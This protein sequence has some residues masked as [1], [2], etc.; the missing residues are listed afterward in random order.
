MQER[1]QLRPEIVAELQQIV[2]QVLKALSEVCCMI[3]KQAA[4]VNEAVIV[5]D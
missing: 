5:K 4:T 1:D 3:V 2:R